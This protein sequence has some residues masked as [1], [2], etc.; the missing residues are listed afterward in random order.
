VV[1][2]LRSGLDRMRQKLGQLQARRDELV[3][4]SR[5]ARAQNRML[6]AV[7]SIDVLDPTSELSRFEDKVRREEARARGK[8]ELAASCLD[9][10]FESLDA[11]AG[12]AEVDARLARLKAGSA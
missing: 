6:D 2:T 9:T 11:L 4:R 3:A 8:E 12:S 5:S 1:D 7:K 10:Q